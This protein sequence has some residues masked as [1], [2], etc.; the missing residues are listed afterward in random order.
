[1]QNFSD[2][3]V[4]P[5]K[6][7]QHERIPGR[8]DMVKNDAGSYTF[9]INDEAYLDRFLILGTEGGTYYVSQK[10]ATKELG[11]R[12]VNMIR[13]DGQTVVS[14]V[15]NMSV[16]GRAPKNDPALFV[17]AACSVFGDDATRKKAFDTLPQIARIGTHLF[18]WLEYRKKLGGGWGYGAKR[19]V[20]NWY[21]EK[22]PNRLAYQVL[23][24][25]SRDG[26]SHRDALRL[27]KPPMGDNP[28]IRFATGNQEV[29]DQ[30][31]MIQ[32]FMSLHAMAPK[33]MDTVHAAV[34]IINDFGLTREMLPTELLG[35]PEIWEALT[36][37]M[38]YEAMIRNLGNMSKVGYLK[39][40]SD[41][42]RKIV[43]KLTDVDQIKRSRIHPIKILAAALTY[44]SGHSVR[45]SGEWDTVPQVVDAL[46]EA[47]DWSFAAVEPSGKN[48][49]LALDVSGSMAGGSL[50]GVPGLSPRVATACLALVTA[51][52]ETNYHIMAFSSSF[53]PL[54]ITGANTLQGAI[55]QVSRLP[56]DWTNCALPMTHALENKLEVDTFVV[57]TDNETNHSGIH[58]CQALDQ[59]RQKMGRDAK[60]IVV[61]ME[62]R[63][64]TIA[65]PESPYMFDVVG[66]DTNTPQLISSL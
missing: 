24:Y 49:M 43:A 18:H 61:G 63:P 25:Q 28:V 19:A 29:P 58:P 10:T 57:Y 15:V 4:N 56:F 30:H 47:F 23:K 31:P 38:G 22:D 3:I 45:G 48:I 12:M 35:K 64:F 41:A 6:T 16:T 54:G 5:K 21:T 55:A 60:L 9:R 34:K 53:V 11:E 37:K 40:M 1:M 20:G 50:A 46:N 59:Y 13:A 27:A 66:F 33:H 51:R 44:G 65:D 62:G 14:R 2:D 39:P 8:E 32:A 42:S 52:V 7:S 26:W 17:H 36:E